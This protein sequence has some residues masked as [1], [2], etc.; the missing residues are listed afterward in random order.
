[1]RQPPESLLNYRDIHA[2]V[3]VFTVR[4]RELD[5]QFVDPV[6]VFGTAEVLDRDLVGVAF[7]EVDLYRVADLLGAVVERYVDRI[8]L[9]C[10]IL[11]NGDLDVLDVAVWLGGQGLAVLDRCRI[12]IGVVIAV[13]VDELPAGHEIGGSVVIVVVFAREV[14]IVLAVD[15]DMEVVLRE[16]ALYR[17]DGRLAYDPVNVHVRA[18]DE[19]D[20]RLDVGILRNVHVEPCESALIAGIEN[21]IHSASYDDPVR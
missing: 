18:V 13:D 6:V 8:T 5:V 2:D 16:T 19:L 10:G 1:M 20:L 4:V 9:P 15:R 12:V 11:R 3:R 14:E 21:D 17:L 7:A